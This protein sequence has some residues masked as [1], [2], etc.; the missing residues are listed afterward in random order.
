V[1]E[2]LFTILDKCGE[3]STLFEKSG[4]AL[5]IICIQR[6]LHLSQE[7]PKT[8]KPHLSIRNGVLIVRA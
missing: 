4:I 8:Q 7:Y 5:A 3:I 2:I 6:R 1:I